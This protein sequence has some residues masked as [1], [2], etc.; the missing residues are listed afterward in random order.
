M[1]LT[2]VTGMGRQWVGDK[3]ANRARFAA[4]ARADRRSA[5]RDRA[6]GVWGTERLAVNF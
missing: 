4:Q 5:A 2:P 3:D 6:A 1:T